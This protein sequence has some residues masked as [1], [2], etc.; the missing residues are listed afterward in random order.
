MKLIRLGKTS[1]IV[2]MVS[3]R[4]YAAL[5]HTNRDKNFMDYIAQ[6]GK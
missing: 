3:D 2:A 5:S 6:L 4:D 1:K